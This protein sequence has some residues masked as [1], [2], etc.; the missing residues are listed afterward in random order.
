MHY[1]LEQKNEALGQFNVIKGDFAKN[2]VDDKPSIEQAAV[3]AGEQF[4]NSKDW[5]WREFI[6]GSATSRAYWVT[7]LIAILILVLFIILVKKGVIRL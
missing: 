1:T 6:T 7:A 5:D 2:Q 4:G 3:A